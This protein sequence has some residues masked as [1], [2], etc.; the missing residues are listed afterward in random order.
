MVI[1]FTYFF[2]SIAHRFVCECWRKLKS[3]F[4][5]RVLLADM[6]EGMEECIP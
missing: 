3:L 2:Y 5:S 4:S 1:C 6:R